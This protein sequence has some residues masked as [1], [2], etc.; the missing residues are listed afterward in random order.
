MLPVAEFAS[1]L[2]RIELRACV[3]P[4]IV[5]VDLV[6]AALS[7]GVVMVTLGL[8]WSSTQVTMV[9]RSLSPDGPRIDACMSLRPLDSVTPGSSRTEVGPTGTSATIAVGVSASVS[10]SR[11]V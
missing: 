11:T 8:A 5:T 9:E 3:L 2:A 1:F 10:H 7:L 4:L 6:T